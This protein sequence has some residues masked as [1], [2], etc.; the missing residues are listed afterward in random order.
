MPMQHFANI[1]GNLNLALNAITVVVLFVAALFATRSKVKKDNYNDLKERV[2]ILEKERDEA[3]IQHL[4]NQKAIANLEGQLKTYKEIPLKQIATS[5][6]E[7]SLSNGQILSVLQNSA[8]VA[9]KDKAELATQHTE[10]QE[11]HHQVINEKG[12]I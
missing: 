10:N 7:L 1:T 9:A 3:R 12:A 8:N 11:V 2:D 5:L 4:E 6:S